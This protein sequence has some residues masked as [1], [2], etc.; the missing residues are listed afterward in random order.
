MNITVAK[1]PASI[2][3]QQSE[4]PPIQLVITHESI[5]GS[6]ELIQA[7]MEMMSETDTFQIV[8]DLRDADIVDAIACWAPMGDLATKYGPRLSSICT[9]VV[10]IGPLRHKN[11]DKASNMLN[12]LRRLGLACALVA[13][14]A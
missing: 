3:C 1:L 10:L 6:D 8:I 2:E 14:V 5:D 7:A 11:K 9:E 12:R 4:L 13:Q